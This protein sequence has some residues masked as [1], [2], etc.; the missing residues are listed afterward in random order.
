LGLF[1]TLAVSLAAVGIYGVIAHSVAERTHEFGIRMALGAGERN[2][3][4][5]VLGEG[6]R[7]AGWGVAGGLVGAWGLTRY[8]ASLLYGVPATDPLTFLSAPLLLAMVALAA[9]YVPARRA[10]KVDPVVA[11]RYE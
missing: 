11:L 3:L 6:L 7:M 5:M 8:L 1:A 10:T 4:G 2:V 9:C